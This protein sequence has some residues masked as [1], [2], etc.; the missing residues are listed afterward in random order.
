MNPSLL[1]HDQNI[2]CASELHIESFHRGYVAAL[3]RD[4]SL[5]DQTIVNA[6]GRYIFFHVYNR[7][8]LQKLLALH[9][10]WSKETVDDRITYSADTITGPVTIHA[11]E[12]AL[13]DTCKLVEET[14]VI[15][16]KSEQIIKRLVVK[17][18][19]P[20]ASVADTTVSPST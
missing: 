5:S 11:M 8:D 16:A 17:C 10:Q 12:N 14:I 2:Q 6:Y 9:P 3:L 18:K 7:D 4:V 15:P 19:Q 20:E 1:L 13:P